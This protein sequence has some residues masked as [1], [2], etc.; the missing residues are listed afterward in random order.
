MFG[1]EALEACPLRCLAV[2]RSYHVV[3]SGGDT[4]AP[5]AIAE[6]LLDELNG[7][8]RTA[9]GPNCFSIDHAGRVISVIRQQK[10]SRAE[11][12]PTTHVAAV[13]AGHIDSTVE[14]DLAARQEII[15]GA[16]EDLVLRHGTN[17]LRAAI[18]P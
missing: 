6:A 9:V 5:V 8:L 3:A 17:S 4:A 7:M 18:S 14:H 16:A 15:V 11:C 13:V 10:C 2:A 12:L 1:H